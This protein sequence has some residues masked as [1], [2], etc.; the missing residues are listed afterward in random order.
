MINLDRFNK[1]VGVLIRNMWEEKELKVIINILK[2]K[3]VFI[4]ERKSP[5]KHHMIIM[6]LDIEN[7]YNLEEL[8][9]KNL[10]QRLQK[11]KEYSLNIKG[12]LFNQIKELININNKLKREEIIRKNLSKVT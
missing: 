6:E 1:T 3:T 2:Q 4:T 7:T 5:N 12:F 11:H 9:F 10:H 8:P